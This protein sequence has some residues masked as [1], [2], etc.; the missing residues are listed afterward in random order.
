MH[1]LPKN[2]NFE[3][4]TAKLKLAAILNAIREQELSIY[5][6]ADIIYVSVAWTRKYV[7]YLLDQDLIHISGHRRDTDIQYGPNDTRRVV[8]SFGPKKYPVK[9]EIITQKQYSQIKKQRQQE[10]EDDL[11]LNKRHKIPHVVRR[12]FLVAALFGNH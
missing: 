2:A 12:D 5:E 4:N 8:Y 11:K 7:N 10:P 3:S 1:K 9:R 6:L